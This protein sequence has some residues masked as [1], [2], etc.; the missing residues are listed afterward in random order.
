[1]PLLRF[2]V[3]QLG[4]FI[5]AA[6]FIALVGDGIASIAAGT[7]VTTPFGEG[8]ASLS[9]GSLETVRG[10]LAERF[11]AGAG[12]A[13]DRAVLAP[14]GFVVVG[15]AGFLLMLLGRRRS[16]RRIGAVS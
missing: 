10:L 14:P 15:I 12:A 3:R 8:W 13:F 9:P 6:A 7:V 16:P 2:I 11:G 4:L 1:M 5:F